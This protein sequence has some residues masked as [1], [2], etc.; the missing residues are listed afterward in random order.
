M[1]LGLLPGQSLLVRC[2]ESRFLCHEKQ[3]NTDSITLPPKLSG[4]EEGTGIQQSRQN[5]LILLAHLLGK[6]VIHGIRVH[7]YGERVAGD[8]AWVIRLCWKSV[9]E[10][11]AGNDL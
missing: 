9:L 10:L 5:I 3:R 2:P 11:A 4:R 7:F 1:Q 8:Q 6:H